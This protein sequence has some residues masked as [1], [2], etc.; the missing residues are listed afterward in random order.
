MHITIRTLTPLW[1]GG[2]DRKSNYLRETGIIGSLRWWY[3]AMVRG[4][5]GWACDPTDDKRGCPD[6]EGSHCAACELFGCTGWQ[7][8]FKLQILDIEGNLFRSKNAD[9]N[10]GLPENTQMVWRFM[11]LR[12]VAEQERWLLAQAI[13]IASKYGSIGGRTPR[14]PQSNK[15]VGRDYGLFEADVPEDYLMLEADNI[16]RWL[17][18][19]GFRRVKGKGWPDLRGFFF[20]S[21]QHLRRKALNELMGISDEGK[22]I[23]YS[24]LDR[25]LRGKV[26]VSKKVFSFEAE[27]AQRLWGYVHDRQ[28]RNEVI[29]RLQDLGIDADNMLTGEEV[30]DDL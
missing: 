5:G 29:I 4:L 10:Y 21:G 17:R 3:E 7:R 2:V 18:T 25:A 1:T 19:K 28:S 8:K 26:G 15:S 12:S 13:R 20:V 16:R 22:P 27:S 6:A 24:S 9:P 14:K 30:L 11:E 23:S